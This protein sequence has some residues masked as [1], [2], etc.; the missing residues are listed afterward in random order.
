MEYT[1]IEINCLKCHHRNHENGNCEAVGGFCTA[2]PAAYCPLIPEMLARCTR[3]E[4]ARER[5]NEA[6]AKWEARAER[7]EKE[8]ARMKGEGK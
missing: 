4:E 6:C 3:L 5:A 1:K 8:L 2:V 7:A